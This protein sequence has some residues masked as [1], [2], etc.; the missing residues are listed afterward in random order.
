MTLTEAAQ[1]AAFEDSV[2]EN[3]TFAGEYLDEAS[4]RNVEFSGCRF[5]KCSFSPCDVVSLT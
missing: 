1:K 2:I 4:G 3:M 5:E